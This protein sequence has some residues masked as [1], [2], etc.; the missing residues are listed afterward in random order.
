[1]KASAVS[2]YLA[3]AWIDRTLFPF[4]PRGFETSHGVMRYVDEGEGKPILFVHGTPVWSFLW[5]RAIDAFRGEHRCIAPDH[6][7]F[8][9][10][11]K[12]HGAPYRPRDHADRLAALV[13][14]LD[15][16]NITLVVHDFGGPIGI[17]VALRDLERVERIVV[18]NTFLWSHEG[19]PAVERAGR[20]MGGRFGRLLYRRF[21]LSPRVLLPS[22]FADRRSLTRDVHRHYLRPFPTPASRE[23]LW[24][25]ARE[26][27]GSGAYYASLWAQRDRLATLPALFVWGMKDPTFT[28]K[29]LA[30]WEQALPQAEAVRLPNVGH[31]VMEE[32][33]ERAIEAIRA[34]MGSP[35]GG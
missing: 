34:F 33:S 31:F 14:H 3:P 29:H 2:E 30:R 12:P 13:R 35:A 8:G 25:L 17:D 21:N 1:M 19:D 28:P 7:G 6:L 20:L 23:A 15:L 26:L 16:R 4:A 24:V 32:G 22:V 10:S 9:L 18:M 27:L 5:R 11:D